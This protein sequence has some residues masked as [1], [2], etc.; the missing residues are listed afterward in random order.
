MT[1]L[2]AALLLAI[3]SAELSEGTPEPSATSAT[4]TATAPD[5]SDATTETVETVETAPDDSSTTAEVVETSPDESSATAETTTLPDAGTDT[6]ANG[7]EAVPADRPWRTSRT[8]PPRQSFLDVQLE[9]AR[10]QNPPRRARLFAPM[11]PPKVIS[12]G[13]GLLVERRFER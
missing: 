13:F 10:A 9:L 1:V 2:F 12:E 3:G 6:V 11:A 4:A 5:E 8:P 7:E